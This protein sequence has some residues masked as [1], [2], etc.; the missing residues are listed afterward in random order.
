MDLHGSN[1][2]PL[3]KTDYGFLADIRYTVRVS[4]GDTKAIFFPTKDRRPLAVP[5]KRPFETS[6]SDSLRYKIH[7]LVTATGTCA[8]TSD[9]VFFAE[10]SSHTLYYRP[11]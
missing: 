7:Y 5:L 1:V 10:A 3:I 8:R 9:K 11:K 4:D 6:K 2:L